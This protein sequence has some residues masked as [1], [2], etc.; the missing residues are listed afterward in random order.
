MAVEK[1]DRHARIYRLQSKMMAGVMAVIVAL[2]GGGILWNGLQDHSSSVVAETAHARA[3]FWQTV[4]GEKQPTEPGSATRLAIDLHDAL[5][6]ADDANT[7]PRGVTE[8]RAEPTDYPGVVDKLGFNPFDNTGLGCTVC[9]PLSTRMKTDL[10]LVQNGHVDTLVDQELGAIETP[11]TFPTM[12]IIGWSLLIYVLGSIAAVAM[13][14][15]R[16][17]R[18]NGYAPATVDWRL[19]GGSEDRYKSLSKTLGLPYFVIAMPI[20]RMLGKDYETVLKR[21]LLLNDDR[22]LTKLQNQV[23]SLPKGLDDREKL[24]GRLEEL[25]DRV[26]Q[27][28]NDFASRGRVFV[29]AKAKAVSDDVAAIAA[30]VREFEEALEFRQGAA[31]DLRTDPKTNPT[32]GD[33]S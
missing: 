24:Q 8:F 18:R 1:K 28:A 21:T 11:F 26:D 9:G 22:Q 12:A 17:S 30:G 10:A 33:P 6:T 14:V 4:A 19:L 23:R 3:D 15:R 27:Q 7:L 16:D 32:I 5:E 29:P 13:A 25:R 31:N 2:G 20:R